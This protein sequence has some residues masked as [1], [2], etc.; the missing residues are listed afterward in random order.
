MRVALTLLL[1]LWGTISA[2]QPFYLRKAPVS[3]YVSHQEAYDSPLAKARG[4]PNVPTEQQENAVRYVAQ[5]HFDPLRE[6]VGGP[7][8]ITSFFRGAQLNAAVKGSKYSDHLANNGI[9]GIDIDQDGR[10]GVNITNRE[11]FFLIKREV[12]FYKLIWEFGDAYRPA[13]VHVSFSD[14]PILNVGSKV[15]RA[16]RFKN[17]TVYEVFD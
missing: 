2:G 4:I 11:L 10:N 1:L 5:Y 17:K 8:F 14:R 15:Y 12:K 6:K 7:L 3:R 9:A 13:W 16:I